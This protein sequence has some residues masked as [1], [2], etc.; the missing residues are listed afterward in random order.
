M[1]SK[2]MTKIFGKPRSI[3]ISEADR[4]KVENLTLRMLPVENELRALALQRDKIVARY[5]PKG[6]LIGHLDLD[7]GRIELKEAP[8]AQSGPVPENRKEK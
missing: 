7:K 6:M 1:R 5:V 8:K 3:K 4:L 2:I